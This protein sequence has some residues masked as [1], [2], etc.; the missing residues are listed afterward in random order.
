[1]LDLRGFIPFGPGLLEV[2]RSAHVFVHVSITEGVPQ[3]L[4]EA[5]AS[6]T[7][8]V[9]TDVGGVAEALQHGQAA[10][11]VPPRDIRALVDAILKLVD[12]ERLRGDLIRRGL[13][14]ARTRTL[15]SEALRV[16]RFIRG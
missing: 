16:A 1:V 3:V 5:L 4:M 13:D 7:P 6:G 12:D 15:E 14:L 11:L 8:V 10:L 2:Y 9:A